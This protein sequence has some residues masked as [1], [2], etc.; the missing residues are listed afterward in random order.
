MSVHPSPTT[1]AATSTQTLKKRT[2]HDLKQR[3]HQQRPFTMLTAYDYTTARILDTAGIEALLVGDS[4]AMT[5]LGHSNTLS[6]TV[7]EMLHHVKAVTRAC[8]QA[9][10]VAD[11][12]FM[13][14]HLSQEASIAN[15][16]RFITEG[17]ADAIKLEGASPNELALIERLSSIG[18]PVVGHLGLTPQHVLRFGGF[19]LQA[20]TAHE[21]LTLLEQ[22]MDLQNAGCV[23]LVVEMV[24]SEV[25]GLLQQRLDI[26]VI[27][28]G[29]GPD[30]DAQVLVIDDLLGRFTAFTPK[31]VRRYATHAEAIQQA[32]QAFQADV[33][34]QA[35]PNLEAESYRMASD[36]YALLLDAL[37]H[38]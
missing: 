29:A 9:W 31:F 36:E 10:V 23:A 14:Y 7:D 5:V 24:P 16:S 25:A 1:T 27:G 18:L 8:K 2:H 32:V 33:A 3:K 30:C 11:A 15:L 22:A 26:P 6:V 38:P 34:T 28:I 4:L 37:T 21:A 17:G 19:K 20:K 13:S 12:P 35:F